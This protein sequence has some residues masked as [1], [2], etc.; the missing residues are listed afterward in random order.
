MSFL[1]NKTPHGFFRAMGVFFFIL[2][3]L[4]ERASADLKNCAILKQDSVALRAIT[5]K[6]KKVFKNQ[7][8]P[9][10]GYSKNQVA[11]KTKIEGQPF[12][13]LAKTVRLE[14]GD[15]CSLGTDPL[16]ELGEPLE[17]DQERLEGGEKVTPEKE[18]LAEKE[19]LSLPEDLPSPQ[20]ESQ[21][22]AKGE[23]DSEGW[24]FG[25]EG[26]YLLS[27]SKKPFENLI[28]PTPPNNVD[29]NEDTFD[30]PF[31][32]S[33]SGGS[34]FDVSV[35]AEMPLA[36]WLRLRAQLGYMQKELSYV[37][38]LNPH[39]PDQSFVTYDQLTPSENSVNFQSAHLTLMP[40]IPF[41][42]ISLNFSFGVGVRVH[43]YFQQFA[44]ERRTAP[45]KLTPYYVESGYNSVEVELLP[46]LEVGYDPFYVYFQFTNQVTGSSHF[47][48]DPQIGA[49][50]NF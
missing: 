9:F 30:S 28:T 20:E 37:Y 25:I 15:L 32:D 4:P 33:V 12:W 13:L 24:S 45:Q 36:S 2:F 17:S 26:G 23:S 10:L 29:V 50:F 1:L 34:G 42:L 3:L 5:R 6:K 40:K 49:G 48:M 35:F 38:R 14:E 44:L 43:Y 46:R 8:F 21:A 31:V 19:E 16:S 47:N 27:T 39:N 18:K 11:I 7:I 22:S 41:N